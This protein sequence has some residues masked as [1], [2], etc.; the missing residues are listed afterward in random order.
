MPRTLDM[1]VL[2]GSFL[3]L[4]FLKTFLAD[5]RM[6]LGLFDFACFIFQI[7]YR[8]WSILPIFAPFDC[9]SSPGV[10]SLVNF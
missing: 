6:T 7:F 5:L 2:E 1:V 10:I 8:F 9:L 4:S 3:G